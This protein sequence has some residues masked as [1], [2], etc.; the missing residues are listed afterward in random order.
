MALLSAYPSPVCPH[1]LPHICLAA[2]DHT[3]ADPK[4]MPGQTFRRTIHSWSLLTR[5]LCWALRPFRICP[6]SPGKR[7]YPSASA[8]VVQIAFFIISGHGN[9][10]PATARRTGNAG[11]SCPS[12]SGTHPALARLNCA[13]SLNVAC[14]TSDL[15][16][17]VGFVFRMLFPCFTRAKPILTCSEATM[18]L[19]F[20]P[21]LPLSAASLLID[22][23]LEPVVCSTNRWLLG[24]GGASRVRLSGG[25]SCKCNPPCIT[26]AD[27]L[28]KGRHSTQPLA[29]AQ[30]IGRRS[31]RVTFQRKSEKRPGHD[32]MLARPFHERLQ[33]NRSRM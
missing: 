24:H 3:T 11:G 9:L 8:T 26:F 17:S 12:D 10:S 22:R 18:R 13:M 1:A 14:F 25:P 21:C 33:T 27:L 2:A 16:A 6:M 23:S 20:C 32:T 7:P 4:A 31:E 28:E 29:I 5:L 15:L 19:A 30:S